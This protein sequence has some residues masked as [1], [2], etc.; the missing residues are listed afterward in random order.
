M[1]TIGMAVEDRAQPSEFKYLRNHK[2]LLVPYLPPYV[3]PNNDDFGEDIIAGIWK[4]L[5]TENLLPVVFHGYETGL[6]EFLNLVN[7]PRTRLCVGA[8]VEN[9]QIADLAGVAWLTDISKV[10]EVAR[11]TVSFC[12]F[13][14]HQTPAVTMPFGKIFL[15][16][17]FD[18]IG[19]TVLTGA[20]LEPNRQALFYV[21]RLGFREVGRLP[22][23]GVWEEETCDE[24]Q[25]AL[26]RR[27][28][29]EA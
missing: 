21:R 18:V 20:V 2:Y 10:G 23:C 6:S 17:A 5:A 27:Q 16:Y 4:R 22:A 25:V 29:E 8:M 15:E 14:E 24:I 9:D 1:T 3:V 7:S 26:T 12:F 11:A 13:T 28:F 19:V